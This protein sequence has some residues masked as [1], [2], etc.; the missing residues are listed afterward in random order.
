MVND[1][2]VGGVTLLFYDKFCFPTEVLILTESVPKL[3][4]SVRNKNYRQGVSVIT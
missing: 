3:D 2:M 4:I 1:S